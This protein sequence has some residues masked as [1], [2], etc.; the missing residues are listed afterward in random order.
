VP[1][2][3]FQFERPPLA[4]QQTPLDVASID[5]N[6]NTDRAEFWLNHAVYPAFY[7]SDME[8]DKDLL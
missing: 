4:F 1:V 5:D 7:R 2:P 3:P 8:S 6:L